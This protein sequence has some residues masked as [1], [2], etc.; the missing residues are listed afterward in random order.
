MYYWLRRHG[1]GMLGWSRYRLLSVAATFVQINLATLI[2]YA[3][4]L[5]LPG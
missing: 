1:K 5:S 3:L 4:C 2:G